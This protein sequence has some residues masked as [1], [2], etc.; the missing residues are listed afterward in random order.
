MIADGNTPQ[1]SNEE[2]DHTTG[3]GDNASLPMDVDLR[4]YEELDDGG[5]DPLPC[6]QCGTP[7]WYNPG[8]GICS[9]CTFAG[10]PNIVSFTCKKC[11][12]V[13][14]TLDASAAVLQMCLICQCSETRYSVNEL[15]DC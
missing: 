11:H 6:V 8:G 9:L 14:L 5:L 13:V 3:P 12:S 2:E 10:D 4:C 15:F 1:I 7:L